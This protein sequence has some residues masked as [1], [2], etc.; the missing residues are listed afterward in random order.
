M[1]GRWT[2]Q[3]VPE[4]GPDGPVGGCPYSP[5]SSQVRPR[6]SIPAIDRVSVCDRGVSLGACAASIKLGASTNKL[7]PESLPQHYLKEGSAFVS[8]MLSLSEI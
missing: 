4:C 5:E 6:S 8:A 1:L 3:P 2:T 7:F